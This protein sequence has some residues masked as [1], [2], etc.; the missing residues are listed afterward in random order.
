MNAN[1]NNAQW[2]LLQ[3][4]RQNNFLSFNTHG[5]VNTAQKIAAGKQISIEI[6]GSGLADNM[7]ELIIQNLTNQG[8]NFAGCR[9][10]YQSS[11]YLNGGTIPGIVMPALTTNWYTQPILFYTNGCN[12]YLISAYGFNVLSVDPVS[13]RA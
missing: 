4:S 5:L 10:Q 1:M 11:C 9:G 12:D 8:F 2:E 6:D 13:H 7:T 3:A